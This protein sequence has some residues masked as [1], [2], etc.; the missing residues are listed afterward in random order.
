MINSDIN[1][2]DIKAIREQLKP[3]PLPK[4]EFAP[5]N[6]N[7]FIGQ[8]RVKTILKNS[9]ESAKIRNA[10]LD[11]I[12]LSGHPG[13]GKT[14]LARLIAEALNV[15]TAYTT[16]SALNSPEE[17]IHLI[18]RVKRYDRPLIF[19]D[20]IHRLKDEIAELLYIPMETIGYIFTNG[21]SSIESPAFTLVGATAGREGLIAKPLYDR[22]G[23]KLN[24]EPYNLKDI[25]KIL[26]QNTK[27]MNLVIRDIDY[28]SQHSC[29]TPRI[30]NNLLKRIRDYVIAR[31]IKRI[32]RKTIEATFKELGLDDLGLD[33]VCRKV[34]YVLF[35]HK[36]PLGLESLARICGMEKETLI[37]IIEPNL[38]VYG[39]INYSS[40]GRELSQR[41]YEHLAGLKIK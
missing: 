19:V 21:I 40:R 25:E 9:I 28:I 24:L 10:R 11:H 8:E 33:T 6:W 17:L 18:G 12:L 34:L 20:E 14:T 38:L 27:K 5:N 37:N 31:Q 1:L 29:Y 39:L 7:E 22:F 36:R 30:A 26:S 3:K 15:E 41:G 13:T 16:A 2:S 4:D 35:Q 23:L 32:D